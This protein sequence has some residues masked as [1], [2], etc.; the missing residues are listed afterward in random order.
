MSITCVLIE[1]ASD[2]DTYRT[3]FA[4]KVDGINMDGEIVW[5]VKG[6]PPAKLKFK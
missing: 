4:T 2:Q 1:I 5:T 6:P 3:A